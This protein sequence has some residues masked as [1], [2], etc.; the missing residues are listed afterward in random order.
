MG[1]VVNGPGE[2]SNADI[3][4]TGAKGEGLIFKGGEII[5]RVKEESIVDELFKEI[6]KMI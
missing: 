1:C 2:A 6:D 5:K 4:I 3:G